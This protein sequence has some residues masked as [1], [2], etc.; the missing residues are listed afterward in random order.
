VL[1]FEPNPETLPTL[2][3]NVAANGYADR[4]EVIAAALGSNPG[5]M[6]FYLTPG[7]DTSSL[8]ADAAPGQPTQVE[9]EVTT[10][11]AAVAGA[12]VQ[13]VKLDVEGGEVEALRGLH[14]TLRRCRPI[15]YAE[16]NPEALA[17]AG[18]S[19]AELAA[20]LRSLDYDVC[21]IDERNESLR[22]FDEPWEEAYVN[23]RCTPQEHGR[24][25]ARLAA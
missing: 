18:T 14:A 5:R 19:A 6:P 22:P 3:R 21:W 8:H 11:D 7:G 4:V 12:E 9:V 20:E 10:G 15:V 1:V 17:A 2:R 16:C 23:L 25:E 24:T 13:V